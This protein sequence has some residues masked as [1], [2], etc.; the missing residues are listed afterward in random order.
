MSRPVRIEYAGALYHVTSRGDRCEPI[1]NDDVDRQLWLSVLAQVCARFHFSVHAYCLMSN[2]YH[3][4]VETL[5]GQLSAGM[6]QL[7]GVYSQAYN[8][9][10]SLVGHVFQGRYNAVL[11]EK[12]S[13]LKE[14]CRY[15]VLNPVRAKMVE[16]AEKWPWSSHRCVLGQAVS[17]PWFDRDCLLSHFGD[18]QSKAMN[19]YREFV[20]AGLTTKR[21]LNDVKHQLFLGNIDEVKDQNRKED[22]L[23][24]AEF[25]RDQKQALALPLAEYFANAKDIATAI[26]NAYESHA[27]SM[28]EIARHSGSSRRTIGRVIRAHET[29]IANGKKSNGS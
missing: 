25:L 24:S 13:Y 26:I 23:R 9:R 3:I 11:C 7:N 18:D 2:H 5:H 27:F 4:L 21:P 14:L 16:A 17:P 15:I 22:I 10:H 29:A 6:R 8:R 1:Y 28:A 12:D 19:A 20:A